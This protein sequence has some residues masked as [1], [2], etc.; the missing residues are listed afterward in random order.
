MAVD[1]REG[2]PTTDRGG[3]MSID[4]II[5]VIVYTLIVFML[6]YWIGTRDAR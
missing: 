3:E 2:A 4:L 1:N 6:G 5:V